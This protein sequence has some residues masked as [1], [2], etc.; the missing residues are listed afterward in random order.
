MPTWLSL[1]IIVLVSVALFADHRRNRVDEPVDEPVAV[2]WDDELPYAA[3]DPLFRPKVRGGSQNG[4]PGS[5]A[6]PLPAR[7]AGPDVW[8]RR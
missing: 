3:S 5:I 8:K 4:H 1:M 2:S 7:R 6:R